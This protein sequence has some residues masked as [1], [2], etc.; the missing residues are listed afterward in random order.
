MAKVVTTKALIQPSVLAATI[1]VPPKAEMSIKQY[2]YKNL[3]G[4]VTKQVKSDGACMR[5]AVSYILWQTEGQHRTIGKAVSKYILDNY[6][7]LEASNEIYYPLTR[8]LGGKDIPFY[9]KEEFQRF[10]KSEESLYAWGEGTD[11]NIMSSL[12]KVQI[13]VLVSKNGKLDGGK[14]IV[15]GE[16]FSR[17]AVLLHNVEEEHYY[18]LCPQIILTRILHF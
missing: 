7:K 13:N 17:K 10:L 8:K 14:P 4:A 1:P 18:Q 12:F 15:F 11:L 16:K 9:S 2:I 6:E 3:P 5:R